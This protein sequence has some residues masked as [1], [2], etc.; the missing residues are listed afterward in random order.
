MLFAVIR[1]DKPGCFELRQST[2]PKHLEYL[3]GVMSLIKSGGAI[4]DENN[5][6]VGSIL[7]INVADHSAAASLAADDPFGRSGPLCEY[8]YR[9]VPNGVCGRCQDRL[10]V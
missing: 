7:F 8:L 4:L 10:M 3:K 2:R 5:I 6:Q 9:S 1:H